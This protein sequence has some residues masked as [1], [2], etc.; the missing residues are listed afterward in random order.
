M[1]RILVVE[2]DYL[3]Q[4]LVKTFLQQSGF[5]VITASDGVSA[6]RLAHQAF[7]DLMLLDMGLPKLNG[8]QAARRLRSSPVTRHIPI[9]ALTAYAM[10]DDHRRAM[11]AGCDAFESKPIDF[12]SLLAKIMA[13]LINK[14]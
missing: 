10:E 4:D 6:L 5:E 8:W 3:I 1:A 11:S 9:I 2:D 13:L 12:A 14:R 7:P